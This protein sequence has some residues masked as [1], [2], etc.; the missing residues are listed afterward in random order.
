MIPHYIKC[1]EEE[2]KH[3]YAK[4]LIDKKLD[5]SIVEDK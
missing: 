2:L 3:N 5:Y 4:T 1:L